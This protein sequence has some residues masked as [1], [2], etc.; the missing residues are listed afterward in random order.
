MK[1]LDRVNELFAAINTKVENETW[2][3]MH[4]QRSICERMVPQVKCKHPNAVSVDVLGFDSRW[5][6]A[7]RDFVPIGGKTKFLDE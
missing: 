4:F 6:V 3:L 5:F 1:S 7:P 2:A